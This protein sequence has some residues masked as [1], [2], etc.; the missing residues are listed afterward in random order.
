MESTLNFQF[1]HSFIYQKMMDSEDWFWVENVLKLKIK[2]KQ[3]KKFVEVFFKM[4][5]FRS[6]S[7]FIRCRAFHN[8]FCSKIHV[9]FQ[10]LLSS[11]DEYC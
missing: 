9:F 10:M 3:M 1:C 5:Y 7:I 8:N 4:R 11:Y 2:N 6:W